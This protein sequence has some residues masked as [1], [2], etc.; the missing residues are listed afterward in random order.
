MEELTKERLEGWAK[1]LKI[2][3]DELEDKFNVKMK[4]AQIALADQELSEAQ[5][6]KYVRKQ[7]GNEI[8]PGR[9][10]AATYEGIILGFTPVKDWNE[11]QINIAKKAFEENSM[12]AISEGVCPSKL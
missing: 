6:E 5:I 10:R 1:Q 3:Y 12:Q 11:Y 8:R 4:T 2:P 9:S 7:M